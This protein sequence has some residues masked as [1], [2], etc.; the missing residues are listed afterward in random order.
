M[1]S[2]TRSELNDEHAA[3]TSNVGF[4]DVSD[5]TLLEIEGADRAGFLHNLCTADI[6]RLATGTGC[7]AF[8]TNVQGK[9]LGHG[10]A[11]CFPDSLQWDTV[12]GQTETLIE[13][14]DRF[15]I[16]ED[17]QLTDRTGECGQLL[18]SG[19]GAVA[20]LEEL[21]I[22]PIPDAP[23]THHEVEF[24]GE[25]C[26]LRKSTL[27]GSTCFQ[28][29]CPSAQKERLREILLQAGAKACSPAAV[30][31]ARVE[32]GSP[33]Y[34]LDITD[35]NL[36]Q[37]VNRDARAISFDKGCYLGQETVAR[38][39]ALGHVNRKLIGLQ[40]AASSPPSAG[41]ELT[42]DGKK[43]GQVTTLVHSPRLGAPLALAYLRR[44][45]NDQSILVFDSP[46]GE[47]SV[48]DLP[49]AAE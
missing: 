7:E 38:V 30:E 24:D 44:E 13:H 27:I 43:V 14:F 21:G 34:A 11:W 31:M 35:Q 40:F 17:V 4:A 19:V 10:F 33:L 22:A 16:S 8:V 9:I 6:K 25:V 26:S 23:L 12:S 18:I 37:E 2:S 45:F 32:A 48:V 15:I 47:A 3:L 28:L 36:P 29:V 41:T 5:R 39:D 20:T 1:N 42:I 46:V 49:V